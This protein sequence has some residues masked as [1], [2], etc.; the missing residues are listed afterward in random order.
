MLCKIKIPF[1]SRRRLNYDFSASSVMQG[2]MM[3]TIPAFYAEKM[4][5]L[6]LRPYSQYSA[7]LNGHNVWTVSVLSHEA[8]DNIITPLLALRSAEIRHKNDIITFA[9]ADTEILSYQELLAENA[10]LSGTSD[11][12][13]LDFITPTAFKS[14]GNYIILP[15][16]RLIFQSLAKRFDTFFGIDDNNYDDL[17]GD[18]DKYVRATDYELASSSFSLE[19]VRIPSFKG[20]ITLRVKAPSELRSYIRMLCRFAE[21][22]GV[23]I[24]TAIGMGSVRYHS[25]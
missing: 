24:K 16:L 3:E 5:S 4:H 13:T 17:L 6:A 15:T 14:S 7:C 2:V 8:Y 25:K 12:L 20:S 11:T 1:E 21:F 18:I 23:G 9:G 19:G 22:S 10:A